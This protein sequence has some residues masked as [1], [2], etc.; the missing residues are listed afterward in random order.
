MQL[1]NCYEFRH[2]NLGLHPISPEKIY[3]FEDLSRANALFN[4]SITRLNEFQ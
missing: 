4:Q 3:L 1:P 2:F